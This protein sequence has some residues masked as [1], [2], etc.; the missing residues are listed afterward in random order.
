M[1]TCISHKAIQENENALVLP[2]PETRVPQPQLV[3]GEQLH[4][5]LLTTDDVLSEEAKL[6][7]EWNVRACPAAIESANPI[8]E[9]LESLCVVSS[10]TKEKISLAQGDPTTFGHLQVPDAAVEAMV[11]ATKSNLCNGY[12]HSAGSHECRKA[13]AD[14]HS[15]SLPLKLTADDVGIT[16]GCSQAIQLCI[17][18][19]ATAG[20]NILIPRPGFPIYE[21]FC[22]YYGVACRF[23][24]LL[25]ERDWEVDLDQIASIAD[26]NTVAWIVNNP[27]N[28]CGSVY[29]YQHL[30]KIANTAEKLKVPLI[31]D[32]IYANMVFGDTEFTPMAAFSMKVPVLTVGGISKRWLVPG[33]RL[34]WIII[35]DPKRILSRGKV[36]EALTRLM[37]MTIGTSTLSQA[38]LSGMLLNTPS[39]FFEDTLNSLKAGAELCF[40]RVQSIKG[41]YCP[42][43]PQG[44]MYIMVRI[45]PAVFTDVSSDVEFASL[46]VKE[47]SVVVLPGTAFGTPNWLR[48]V[49]ATPLPHLEEAWHRI[50]LFCVRHRAAVP[51]TGAELF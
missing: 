20:A 33:W 41:L 11:A 43:K 45:D 46:L 12:T 24:D 16:V 9:L 3:N 21:T 32:E 25:P 30:V 44:A 27:S 4:K 36:V 42:T 13:V 18:A 34:G 39:S 49:F 5:L 35:A 28:P 1:V 23:Y 10:K 48:I 17:A 22:K 26:S 51:Y 6:D 47:E 31:S 38:A 37:Q 14:Y 50:D 40:E 8:R 7:A 19:L 15:S 2:L 29:K